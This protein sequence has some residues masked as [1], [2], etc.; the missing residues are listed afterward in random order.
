MLNGYPRQSLPKPSACAGLPAPIFLRSSMLENRVH[1]KFIQLSCNLNQIQRLALIL[2]LYKYHVNY[3]IYFA[4]TEM[5]YSF[6]FGFAYHD[7]KPD[8][9]VAKR[10]GGTSGKIDI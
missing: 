9:S 6:I 5:P 7:V 10:S 3:V 1:A 4:I 8:E 2:S